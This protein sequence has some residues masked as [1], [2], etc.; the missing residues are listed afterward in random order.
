MADLNSEAMKAIAS[1]QEISRLVKTLEHLLK[2]C[3]A[4]GEGDSLIAQAAKDGLRG[5]TQ[6]RQSPR[7]AKLGLS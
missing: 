3:L 7:L 4:A 1:E 6:I 5:L 2:R